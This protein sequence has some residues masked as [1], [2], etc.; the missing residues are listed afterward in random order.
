MDSQI[1][2]R[3]L[4]ISDT[5]GGKVSYNHLGHFDVAVHS[6]DLTEGSYLA[7]F[8]Q[9]IKTL[10]SIQ[11]PLKLVIA[12]NHDFTLD[13]AIFKKK[14]ASA[15]PPLGE[16]DTAV[17]KQYGLF[18]EARALFESE[19][20]KA[21]GIRFLDEGVHDFVLKNGAKLSVFASPYTPGVDEW[22]FQY[23]PQAGHR[24]EIPKV[25]LAITHGPPQGVFDLAESRKRIGCPLLFAA[26]AKAQPKAHLFGHVH[27]GW[28]AKRVVW[29]EH[30][31]QEPSHWS[32]INNDESVLI[33]SLRN[34]RESKFDTPAGV[35]EKQERVRKLMQV[36][37][38]TAEVSSRTETARE[39]VF[40]NA[41]VRGPSEHLQVPW[42]V[43]LDLSKS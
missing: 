31:E 8:E 18:G 36:G 35:E 7:E 32:A 20:A 27:A 16:A 40:V 13:T 17:K 21:A 19:S 24:W 5:H 11:A 38:C 33:A 25:D 43:E 22:A 42:C 34:L 30:L 2:T 1:R 26:I 41:A 10:K 9:A 39:T 4:V 14:L 6:G 37:Y 12:G 23:N 29:Q 15:I 3:I 28:G